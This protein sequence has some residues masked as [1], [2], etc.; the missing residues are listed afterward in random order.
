M[1]LFPLGLQVMTRGVNDRVAEDV[2]FAKFV[3][4]SLKRHAQGDWGDMCEEDK[5]TNQD[6]L[7]HGNRLFSAYV[8]DGLPKI[9]VVT[10][11]D[12][13]ATTVLFPEEY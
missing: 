7:K 6:A 4:E 12:R 3:V 2:A 8:H 1:G 5:Q 11:A 9:W 13:S 10:E